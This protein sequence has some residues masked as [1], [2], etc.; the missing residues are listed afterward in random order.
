V[1]LEQAEQ[2]I[3]GGSDVPPGKWPDTVAV[4]GETGV[5]SGTLIAPDVV[6]TAGHCA[7]ITPSTVVANT[8]DYSQ[9]G[10]AKVKVARTAAYPDWDTTYDVSLV[11]LAQPINS[12]MPRAIGTSC[13][14][15]DFQPDTQVRLVGFGATDVQGVG[16]NT[17]L[18]EAMTTV[19]DPSCTGGYGCNTMVAPGGEFV[20]GGTGSADSCF[21]DSGGPVYLETSRGPIVIGAVSRGVNNA[22]TPCGAGGIYVRTDKVAA[23]IEETAGKAVMKD[24]CS[25]TSYADI[26]EVPPSDEVGC[27]ATGAGTSTLGFGALALG[28]VLARRR[29]RD[30]RFNAIISR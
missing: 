20:A 5:C 30:Y 19:I 6:L 17:S 1:H 26:N 9:A 13:S 27:S 29:H 4:L 23:W 25:G 28:V 12:V 15:Q 22:A 7:D 11:I 8:T 3:V 10:G 2:A 18:K 16:S 21:G 24:D 14:F